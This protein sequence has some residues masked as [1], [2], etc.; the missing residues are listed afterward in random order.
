MAF[1]HTQNYVRAISETYGYPIREHQDKLLFRIGRNWH[2]TPFSEY[3][4]SAS[5][6]E[7]EFFH[8]LLQPYYIKVESADEPDR[9][10]NHHAYLIGQLARLD[11]ALERSE[12]AFFRTRQHQVRKAINKAQRQ[13]WKVQVEP[14]VEGLIPLFYRHYSHYLRRRHGSPPLGLAHFENMRRHF[15][16]DMIVSWVARDGQT[17]A[18]LLG[19]V[20]ASTSSCQLSD[21]VTDLSAWPDRVSDL[22]HWGLIRH[23]RMRGLQYVDFGICRYPGQAFYKRKWGCHFRDT[24]MFTNRPRGPRADPNRALYRICRRAWRYLPHSLHE[25]IGPKI[26]KRLGI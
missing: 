20:D 2:N 6:I 19:Y 9:F 26:R 25:W 13:G 8:E 11:L 14:L 5:E 10:P 16:D 18:W 15:G 3:G 21:I 4:F 22:A 24:K 23:A 17:A 12:E 7:A 1:C